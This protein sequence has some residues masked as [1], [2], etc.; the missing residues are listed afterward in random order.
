[1]NGRKTEGLFAKLASPMLPLSAQVNIVVFSNSPHHMR[2]VK[3]KKKKFQAIPS[4]RV[5]PAW[6]R[7]MFEVEHSSAQERAPVDIIAL[8][9]S[10]TA[11]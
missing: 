5:V 8:K 3:H 7:V 10:S 1:M 11:R 9:R 4:S 2:V 6:A